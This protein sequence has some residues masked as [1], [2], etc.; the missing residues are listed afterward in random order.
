[1]TGD[2]SPLEQSEASL[3]L[4][5]MSSFLLGVCCLTEQN[6][7]S[8]CQSVAILRTLSQQTVGPCV[9]VSSQNIGSIPIFISS[10]FIEILPLQSDFL[11]R[12][13]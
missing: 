13:V 9:D 11:I 4:K 5:C 12:T 6:G 10:F 8:V 3:S 1:M 2:R 7:L